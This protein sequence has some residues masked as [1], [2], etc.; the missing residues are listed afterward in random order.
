MGKK[1]QPAKIKILTFFRWVMEFVVRCVMEFAFVFF[2]LYMRHGNMC[3]VMANLLCV[4]EKVCIWKHVFRC[5][6]EHVVWN[7]F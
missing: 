7:R 5:V 2:V 3:S 1:A 4:M 6:K